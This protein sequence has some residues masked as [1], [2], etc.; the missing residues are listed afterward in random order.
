MNNRKPLTSE[1]LHELDVYSD[2]HGDLVDILLEHGETMS[3]DAR[4]A[5][6][7][8]LLAALTPNPSRTDFVSFTMLSTGAPHLIRAIEN[9]WKNSRVFVNQF[10]N[11][12]SM[13]VD[14]A[15]V[16]FDEASSLP[17]IADTIIDDNNKIK[18]PLTKN[19]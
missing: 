1:Q 4:F 9:T 18:D 8:S 15:M 19:T 3:D 16:I 10:Q 12:E 13:G 14:L 17:S 5:L 7:D 6:E 2:L 11:P